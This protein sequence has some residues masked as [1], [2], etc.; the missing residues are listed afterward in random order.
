MGII[1]IPM[2]IAMV[3]GFSYPGIRLGRQAIVRARGRVTATAVLA[4]AS[5]GLSLVSVVLPFALAATRQVSAGGFV[6]IAA[7]CVAGVAGTVGSHF[8]RRFRATGRPVAGLVGAASF[9]GAA[10]FPLVWFWLGARL[11]IWF[12]ICWIY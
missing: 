1:L 3:L 8:T 7:C 2:F 11:A 5:A 12:E 10:G 9:L 4:A 6:L